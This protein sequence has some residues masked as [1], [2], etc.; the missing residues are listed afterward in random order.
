[1][2]SRTPKEVRIGVGIAAGT[3]SEIIAE[4]RKNNSDFDLQR[5]YVVNIK[6]RRTEP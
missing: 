6:K 4:Y 5:E 3:V 2:S 1:M